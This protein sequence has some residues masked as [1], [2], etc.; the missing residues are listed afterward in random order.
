MRERAQV[1]RG[2]K[3]GR[4]SLAAHQVHQRVSQTR[5]TPELRSRNRLDSQSSDWLDKVFWV[6]EQSMQ[7]LRGSAVVSAEWQGWGPAKATP[8]R[9]RQLDFILRAKCGLPRAPP[10]PP[11]SLQ[12]GPLVCPRTS[13]FQQEKG[14]PVCGPSPRHQMFPV[15]GAGQPG[16]PHHLPGAFPGA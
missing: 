16:K 14:C 4:G 11:I 9:P 13:P 8:T 7:R 6:E 2:P 10:P 5:T 12:D 3:R 1:Y 15:T